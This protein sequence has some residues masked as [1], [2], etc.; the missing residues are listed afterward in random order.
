LLH[1]Y[2]LRPLEKQQQS[3]GISMTSLAGLI[4]MQLWHYASVATAPHVAFTHQPDCLLFLSPETLIHTPEKR[5]LLQSNYLGLRQ[6]FNVEAPQAARWNAG[7]ATAASGPAELRDR[8]AF[9]GPSP[10]SAAF[11]VNPMGGFAEWK[12]TARYDATLPRYSAVGRASQANTWA[13]DLSAG[14]KIIPD[15]Q[16]G[17]KIHPTV[18]L[19]F[20]VF[21]F[22]GT[23]LPTPTY[24]AVVN[25]AEGVLG[26][27]APA[28]A[29]KEGAEGAKAGG[30]APKKAGRR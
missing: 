25:P 7:F 21:G 20:P 5:Q 3:T 9:T 27:P 30:P 12:D 14:T 24:R 28:P 19:T 26:A 16:S 15:L 11:G 6:R 10:P 8:T 23:L 2:L 1:A 4:H 22:G 17:T 13:A 18:P 29:P